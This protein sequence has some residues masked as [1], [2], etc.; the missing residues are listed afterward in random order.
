VLLHKQGRCEVPIAPHHVAFDIPD[1]FVVGYG[2]D[3]RD[4]YRNLPH[5]AELEPADLEAMD[6]EPIY[7]EHMDTAESHA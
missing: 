7:I 3:Y 4:M 5:V 1:V 2:L 6:I